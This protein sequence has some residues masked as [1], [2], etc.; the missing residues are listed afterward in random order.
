M[1]ETVTTQVSP[2]PDPQA[3]HDLV[4]INARIDALAGENK[5]L[6]RQNKILADTLAATK[7]VDETAI[8]EKAKTAALGEIDAR[9]ATAAATAKKTAARQAVLDG[10]LKEVHAK[11]PELV[12]LPDSDDP[13]V[14]E[15]AAQKVLARAREL[16]LVAP[17]VG[18]ASKDGGQVP[19][20]G[21]AA[22]AAPA[23]FSG[24]SAGLAR[25]AGGLKMPT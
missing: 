22:A 18:G 7:P 10:L 19:G 17:D 6:A 12:Q 16:K 14:L 4:A 25:F 5:E 9:S 1:A 2:A 21:A 3:G 20:G 15:T 11:I 23:R 13:A 24:L 8:A